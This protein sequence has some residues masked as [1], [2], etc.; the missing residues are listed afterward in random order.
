MEEKKVAEL[1]VNTLVSRGVS[2]I[3]DK[4]DS[5]GGPSGQP[6]HDR[7]RVLCYTL[8][9]FITLAMTTVQLGADPS[10]RGR[11]MA[12]WALA[13]A[14]TTPIGAPAIGAVAQHFGATAALF[15]GAVAAVA[16]GATA[17]L[18]LDRQRAEDPTSG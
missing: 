6:G 11:V 17:L 14:G 8:Y 15:A 10:A 12:W 13:F 2:R 7:E 4:A 1:L 9:A 18:W 16:A 3:C 5:G